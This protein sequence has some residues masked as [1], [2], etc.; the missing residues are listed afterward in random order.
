MGDWSSEAILSQLTAALQTLSQAVDRC[1]ESAWHESQKDYPFSQVV[2]HTLFFTDYYLDGDLEAV[3]EQQF[4]R[5]HPDYFQDY[6]ELEWREPRNLYDRGTTRKYLEFCLAKCRARIE[7][8]NHP[9]E[10]CGVDGFSFSRGELYI[11]LLRHIQHHAAQLGLRVQW[12]TGTELDW[13][14]GQSP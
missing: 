5:D 10:Q 14:R 4:H 9:A 13:R 11:Y 3:K 7:T 12:L 6:E 8:E 2:F 1:P